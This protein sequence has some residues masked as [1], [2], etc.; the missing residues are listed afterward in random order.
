[1]RL[2]VQ[3][4]RQTGNVLRLHSIPP[5]EQGVARLLFPAGSGED[6][7]S[8]LQGLRQGVEALR[9][10]RRSLL[11]FGPSLPQQHHF[12]DVFASAACQFDAP[13]ELLGR[14]AMADEPIKRQLP[15]GA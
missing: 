9:A 14:Q 13:G 10:R 4:V 15:A 3:F 12:Q 7:R 11:P 5:E 8:Q 6:L 1:M 2:H